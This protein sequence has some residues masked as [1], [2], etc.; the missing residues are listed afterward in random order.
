MRYDLAKLSHSLEGDYDFMVNGLVQVE[1]TPVGFNY[2]PQL[3]ARHKEVK[4]LFHRW[5]QKQFGQY[6]EQIKLIESLLFLSMAPLHADRFASQ[7]AFIAR[8]LQTFT[9]VARQAFVIQERAT[10]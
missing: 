10:A 5:F 3:E 2:N 7:Q 8:G 4:A 1:W 9:D 6:Y